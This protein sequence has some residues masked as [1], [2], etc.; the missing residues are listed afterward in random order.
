MGRR[1]ASPSRGDRSAA[2]TTLNVLAIIPFVLSICLTTVFAQA[3]SHADGVYS[4]TAYSTAG[5]TA[6]GTATHGRIVSADLTLLP[7]N[8]R[9][10]ITGAGRYS[11]EYT[12][13]DTGTAIK[14]R[15]LDIYI[16]NRAAAKRFGRRRVH[17]KVI[18]LGQTDGTHLLH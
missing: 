1:G 7:M 6:S 2:G 11:G 5:K 4:A 13:R 18:E 8:S 14:G 3:R 9:I 10:R 17:V 15:R 16:P 12:V